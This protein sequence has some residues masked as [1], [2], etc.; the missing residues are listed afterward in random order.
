MQPINYQPPNLKD[1]QTGL[2]YIPTNTF[3]AK[4]SSVVP[5]QIVIIIILSLA[6]FFIAFVLSTNSEK[7]LTEADNSQ[8]SSDNSISSTEQDIE[9]EDSANEENPND[10][11]ES[12]AIAEPLAPAVIPTEDNN[13]GEDEEPVITDNRQ[14]EREPENDIDNLGD[15]VD[16]PTDDN[17]DEPIIEEPAEDYIDRQYSHISQEI[18]DLANRLELTYEAKKELY[19]HNPQIFDDNQ[20]AGYNCQTDA[21]DVVIYG[22][23]QVDDIDILRTSTMETTI[24]HELLHAIYYDLF[25]HNQTDDIDRQLEEFKITR[26]EEI[27]KILELYE[28]HYDYENPETRRWAEYSEL[29]SFIGTQFFDLPSELEEHYA[30]YFNNR[31]KVVNFYVSWQTSFRLKQEEY[32]SFTTDVYNQDAQYQAC[33]Y[34]LDNSL[35]DCQI[36]QTDREAFE[37]YAECLRSHLTKFEDC[38][39]LKP[40][41]I[42]YDEGT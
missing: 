38:S 32:Q 26:S 13:A 8:S 4:G 7:T 12:V 9:D 20:A 17:S 27:E 29:H 16:E 31:R 41:F 18:K 19:D 42:P 1:S 2:S 14:E 3:D 37:T 10:E 28:G 40:E 6:A 30:K 24:A 35:D 21:E 36:Y 34:D 15:D 11:S 39:S 5:Q 25:L 33:F 23:W 22:C